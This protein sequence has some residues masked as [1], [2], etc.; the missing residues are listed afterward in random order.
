V[1]HLPNKLGLLKDW[2]AVLDRGKTEGVDCESHYEKVWAIKGKQ[3]L[4]DYFILDCSRKCRMEHRPVYCGTNAQN[5][6]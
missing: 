3:L 4:R 1:N 6:G 5:E 2:E